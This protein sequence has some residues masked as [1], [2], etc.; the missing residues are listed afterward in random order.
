[1][2]ELVK[3]DTFWSAVSALATLAGAAA[4]VFAV[5][6]LRFEAWLKAQEIWVSDDFTAARGKVFARLDNPGVPWTPEDEAVGL[7]LCRRVDEF[8]RLAPYLGRRRMLKVW[9][10]PLAKAWLVLEPLVRKERDRT[11]W[12][13]KWDAFETFGNRALSARPHLQAKQQGAKQAPNPPLQPTAYVG[14]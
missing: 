10:D 13:T 4:I 8:V 6:Q 7:K 5:W 14:G 1:M 9:G 11:A 12:Q 3:S 2:L